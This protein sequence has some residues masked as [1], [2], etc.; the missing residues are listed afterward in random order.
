MYEY[1]RMV[2]NIFSALFFRPT[3]TFNPQTWLLALRLQLERVKKCMA[4]DERIEH[5]I[6]DKLINEPIRYNYPQTFDISHFTFHNHQNPQS[7][8]TSIP[9]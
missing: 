3:P 2:S 9:G 4:G 5:N 8:I 7:T 6:F 1:F